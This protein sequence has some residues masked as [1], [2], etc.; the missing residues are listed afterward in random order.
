MEGIGLEYG[1]WTLLIRAEC[2]SKAARLAVRGF[3]R[4]TGAR[5][6][7]AGPSASVTIFGRKPSLLAGS[8]SPLTCSAAF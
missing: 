1:L 2:M 5:P 4:S 7:D 6:A 8:I 3:R